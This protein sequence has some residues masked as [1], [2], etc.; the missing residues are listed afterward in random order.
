MKLLNTSVWAE[1]LDTKM[2][3]KKGKSKEAFSS[4]VKELMHSGRPQNQ[5]VAIAYK[6]AKK[7][8]FGGEVE[9]EYNVTSEHE[10]HF[11]VRR[12]SKEFKVA[13]KGLSRDHI[14]KIQKMHKGGKVQYFPDG[15]EVEGEEAPAMPEASTTPEPEASPFGTPQPMTEGQQTV[16]ATEAFSGSPNLPQMAPQEMGLAAQAANQAN[17]PAPAPTDVQ[18]VQSV[19]NQDPF[20]NP[21]ADYQKAYALQHEGNVASLEGNKT[22][23]AADLQAANALI[24]GQQNSFQAYQDHV[25]PIMQNLDKVT[26][27]AANQ[28]IDFNRVWGNTPGER[29]GNKILA[30]ISILLGG[31]GQGLLKSNHNAALDAINQ[32]IDRDVQQQ[33][34]QMDQKNNL[35]KMYMGQLGNEQAAE[36]ATQ[37]HLTAVFKGQL[38]RAAAMSNDPRAMAAFK[39]AESYL[40]QQQGDRAMKM[41]EFQIGQKVAT[42]QFGPE[43]VRFAGNQAVRLPNGNYAKATSPEGKNEVDAMSASYPQLIQG[44]QRIKA[45]PQ[46]AAGVPVPTQ[47]HQEAEQAQ[48]QVASALARMHGDKLTSR[49]FPIYQ[50]LVGG[51]PTNILTGA[52]KKLASGAMQT[53]Q[54]ELDTSFKTHVPAYQPIYKPSTFKQ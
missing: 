9:N 52:Y 16:P 37:S 18:S 48:A 13:K 8:A 38:A 36:L 30:G 23:A 29:T 4:N 6:E 24:E 39:D 3:L 34:A 25:K 7:M 44:L 31:I 54:D 28:K 21:M 42:G 46:F 27:D 41:A 45:L 5:T 11:V 40:N 17:T 53:A 14:G 32:N 12:G 19:P 1:R 51:S 20:A 26:Q 33:K 10:D 15:G 47:A 49:N 2:P 50:K 43:L 22:Q 35:Y